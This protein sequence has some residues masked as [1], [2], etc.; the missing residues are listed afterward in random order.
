M[1]L[2]GLGTAVPKRSFTQAECWEALQR[3]DRPELTPRT[4]AILQGIL[5]HDNGIARRSLALDSLDESFEIDPDTLHRRFA[6]H[7]PALASQAAQAA[8]DDAG[9]EPR[10]VD[11]VLVS[12]C[13]GYLCPG[14]T[15]YVAER[16]GLRGDVLPLD[17][18]GQGCGAALPNLRA[19]EAL[20]AAGG[21]GNV[22][23]VCV[24]VCSAAFYLDGDLGVLVS[25]CLF[26]DGAGAVVVSSRPPSRRPL[27]WRSAASLTDPAQREALRFEQRGGM[28]RNVLTLPVPDLAARRARE[29]LG[30]VL[31]R[32][33]LGANDIAAWIL[34]AGGRK[35][36][37]ALR[38]SIGLREGDLA[39]SAAMLRDY[40]NLSSPFVIF[41]LKAALEGGAPRGRWW[42]SSFG[43]GFSCH[44]ALL[45]VA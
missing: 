22:L 31:A 25:A 10:A 16:L 34:H 11:A 45:E 38:S 6:R 33:G 29:V 15:S 42:M 28:L 17:L 30:T 3:A 7:A 1:F 40:G 35:V 41:V 37:E 32:E 24:E 14:L 44:G 9:L 18:V 5:T 20:L 21:F 36:L 43:A 12:T 39:W 19:A 13:T 26:G 27:R 23:C 2:V 8:L 4:R